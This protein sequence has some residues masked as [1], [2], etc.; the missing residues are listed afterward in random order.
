LIPFA[1]GTLRLHRIEAA[2][3]QRNGASILILVQTDFRREGFPPHYLCI[4]GVWQDHR[5]FARLRDDG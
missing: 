1:F 2:C 5:L 3:I 4:D